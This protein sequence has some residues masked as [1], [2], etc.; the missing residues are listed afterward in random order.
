M[1]YDRHD[2]VIVLAA[3]EGSRLRTLTTDENG[4]TRPK[5]FC[6]LY[7][8][9]SLL[10]ETLARA[11][12]ITSSERIVVVV[13]AQH[14]C[15]WRTQLDEI[16]LENVI[17]QPRNLGTAPGVLLPLMYVLARD[18]E[19]RVTVLPSDHYV[20]DEAVL[21]SSLRHALEGIE[22]QPEGLILLGVTPDRPETEYGWIVP[23]STTAHGPVSI[24][25]FIEK[26]PPNVAERLFKNG[27]LWSSFLFAT[28]GDAL[29]ARFERCLPRWVEA[30]RDVD[31]HATA[32][33]ERLYAGLHE[34]DFSREILQGDG[35]ALRTLRVPACGWTDLGTPRRVVECLAGLDQR[36]IMQR[37]SSARPDR[38]A[39]SVHD[40]RTAV[41][42]SRSAA[43]SVAV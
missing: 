40:L 34:R 19:S 9:K 15:W 37:A 8:E 29:L 26:P 6:S 11:R 22:S 41:L 2:W 16:P 32:T 23:A 27:G 1:N 10:Q 42:R 17:V 13:A 21:A 35:V 38:W 36:E 25:A 28:N 43:S 4:R 31:T 24:R 33:L 18:A 5:Q 14:D 39:D 30:L 7:G 12:R 20:R 3:G